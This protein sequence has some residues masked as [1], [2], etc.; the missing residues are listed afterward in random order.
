MILMKID[1]EIFEGEFLERLNRFTV[2]IKY[3]DKKIIAHLHDT[4]RLEELLIPKRRIL[5]RKVHGKKRKTEFD[6]LA[7]KSN[8]SWVI[9]D[10]RM[11]NIIVKKLIENNTLKYEILKENV[12]FGNSLI[13]FML[14]NEKNTYIVEV[15]GC[16]LCKNG[17]A[18]FPDAPTI[19]GSKQ[20]LNML[21][22]CNFKPM[23]IFVVMRED[24]QKI[25]INYEID[26]K[27]YEIIKFGISKNL[28]IRAF[29]VALKDNE[30]YFLGEVPFFIE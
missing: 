5:F 2:V 3:F 21:N 4:G 7:I 16:T 27:F 18:L 24:A 19:R 13:D 28:I 8:S 25:S 9:T 17:I 1:G 14:K 26:K 10:S 20:L 23:I 6:V 11:P 12:R 30:I 15:K 22:N 29:K